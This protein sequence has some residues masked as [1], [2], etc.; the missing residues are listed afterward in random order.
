MK[1]I[2]SLALLSFTLLQSC[3][4]DELDVAPTQVAAPAGINIESAAKQISEKFVLSGVKAILLKPFD[5]DPNTHLTTLYYADAKGKIEPLLENFEVKQVEVTTTGIYVLTNYY[6]AG[7]P[8]AFFVKYDNSWVQLKGLN[9][10]N[11]FNYLADNGDIVFTNATRTKS[12]F[13]NTKTLTVTNNVDFQ[14]YPSEN[15]V[16][17]TR[18][19]KDN[20]YNTA[21]GETQDVNVDGEVHSIV[22]INHNSMVVLEILSLAGGVDFRVMD[23]KTGKIVAI[24]KDPSTDELILP[25]TVFR[26]AAGNGIVFLTE[27]VYVRDGE[28]FRNEVVY[29]ENGGTVKVMNVLHE[30]Y[31]KGKNLVAPTPAYIEYLNSMLRSGYSYKVVD[32]LLY[33]TGT[34][35]KTGKPVTGF[36]DMKSGV[37]LVVDEKE[38]FSSVNPL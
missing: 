6:E 17:T 31:P 3:T 20:V 13:L 1:K 15:L 32:N 16:L 24:T 26:N 34:V 23:M 9:G 12:S 35:I 18:N 27:E 19:G 25:T 5:S 14:L 10:V 37:N 28:T 2:L 11:V 21:T 29:T 38:T 30:R 36:Y 8:I 7:E 4:Q 22:S 33:Y